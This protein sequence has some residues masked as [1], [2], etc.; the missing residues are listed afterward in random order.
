MIRA[1]GKIFGGRTDAGIWGYVS[2]PFPVSIDGSCSDCAF[3]LSLQCCSDSLY[4]GSQAASCLLASGLEYQV[5]TFPPP[6]IGVTASLKELP[7][8]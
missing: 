4:P 8:D 1:H 3:P 2:S 7:R 6:C 5:V